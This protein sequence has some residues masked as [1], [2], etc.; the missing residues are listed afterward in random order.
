MSTKV[1]NDGGA[2]AALVFSVAITVSSEGRLFTPLG[3]QK[4]RL[5]PEGWPLG[6]VMPFVG[7]SAAWTLRDK[8]SR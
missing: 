5:R 8:R 1:S 6:F 4:H 7:S 2:D 3:S